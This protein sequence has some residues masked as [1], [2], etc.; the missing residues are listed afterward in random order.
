M[1]EL[2]FDR[3]HGNPPT[4]CAAFAPRP[5]VLSKCEVAQPKCL[6]LSTN[7]QRTRKHKSPL[8]LVTQNSGEILLFFINKSWP[9]QGSCFLASV[10]HVSHKI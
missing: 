1:T 7:D 3:A 2:C 6:A 4:R 8:K 10:F 9:I 5:K